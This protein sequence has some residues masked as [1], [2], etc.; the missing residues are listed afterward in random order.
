MSIQPS[1]A[2]SGW[3]VWAPERL[4]SPVAQCVSLPPLHLGLFLPSLLLV[5]TS[6]SVFFLIVSFC[7]H[8]GGGVAH[9]PSVHFL[10]VVLWTHGHFYRVLESLYKISFYDSIN[11]NDKG[12][13][14]PC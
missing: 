9:V 11:D 8:V 7:L 3:H 6:S 14:A 2:A 12:S 1:V 13:E 4:R 5:M 10:L